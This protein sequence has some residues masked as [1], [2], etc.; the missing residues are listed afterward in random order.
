MKRRSVLLGLGCLTLVVSAIVGLAPASFAHEGEEETSAKELVLQAIAL[1]RGQPEQTEAIED[2][3]LDA[4]N[5]EDGSGVDPA[6]LERA[7]EA[8]EAGEVHEARDLLEEAVGAAPHRVV[9]NPGKGIR[10]P[11]PEPA[12]TVQA[13]PVLHETEIDGGLQGPD[14]TAGWV[15]V[16]LA[17]IL[18]L[19]GFGLARRFR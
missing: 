8:F 4:L 5:A 14:G 18:G 19:L 7:D 2:K 16:G 11:A 3:M 13:A 17:A 10:S 12:E 9:D 6:L 1:L 15:L